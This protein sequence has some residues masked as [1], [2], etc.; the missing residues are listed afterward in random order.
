MVLAKDMVKGKHSLTAIEFIQELLARVSETHYSVEE[1]C[2]DFLQSFD[3]KQ[4]KVEFVECVRYTS[5]R[6]PIALVDT[7]HD[8]LVDVDT[9]GSVTFFASDKTWRDMLDIRY[10]GDDESKYKEQERRHMTVLDDYPLT[11]Y[12]RQV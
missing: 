4:G 8:I 9:Y 6:I 7:E 2:T 11:E 3:G 10:S 5:A 12:D 1:A